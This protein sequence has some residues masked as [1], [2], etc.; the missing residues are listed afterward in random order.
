MKGDAQKADKHEN[1]MHKQ[2]TPQCE[3]QHVVKC[4]RKFTT[5]VLWFMRR[6]YEIRTYTNIQ[7]HTYKTHRHDIG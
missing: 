3:N 7:T 6:I 1:Q 4:I 2:N 5:S